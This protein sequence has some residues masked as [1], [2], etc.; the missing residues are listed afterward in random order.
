MEDLIESVKNNNAEL[1]LAF[2]GDGDRVGLITN[3]G[4]NIFPDKYMMMLSEN[5]LSKQSLLIAIQLCG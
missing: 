2:D 3:F 5:I 4:E 1:G